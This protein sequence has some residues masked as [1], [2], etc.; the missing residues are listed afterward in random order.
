[1]AILNAHVET[2]ATNYQMVATNSSTDRIFDQ[3]FFDA[4]QFAAILVVNC[5]AFFACITIYTN[6]ISSFRI[7]FA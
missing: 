3:I 7:H 5:M 4:W 6:F 2:N 1:M